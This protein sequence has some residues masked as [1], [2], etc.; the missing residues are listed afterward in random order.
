MDQGADPAV[1]VSVVLACRNAAGHVAGQLEALSRQRPG[2]WGPWELVVSDNGSTD[3]T[4][5]VVETF[6]GRFPRLV[7]VDSAAT[8]GPGAARN[9]GVRAAAGDRILFCDADD[10]VDGGWLAAMAEGLDQHDLVAARLDVEALNRWPDLRRWPGGT[11]LLMG[12]PPF[13]PYTMSCALGVR[14]AVHEALGGFDPAFRDA[15]EDCDYCFRAQLRG[16]SLGVAPGAVVQYRYRESPVAV[17]QQSRSYSRGHVQ[18]WL[19]YRHLG[20]ARPS[21][22]RGLLSWGLL[23]ARLL[24]ALT[25]RP[26]LLRWMRRL[27]WRVGRLE[28]SLRHRTWAL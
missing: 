25:S 26:R 9:A 28:A 15:A 13:L 7:V 21:P 4:V 17:M 1:R 8:P 3:G 16:Y 18:L 19:A 6:R 11:G 20:L 23:P 10:R 14:R 22:V 5:A 24:P 2:R 12:R 27:G